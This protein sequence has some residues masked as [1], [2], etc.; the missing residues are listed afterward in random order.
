MSLNGIVEDRRRLKKHHV[1][2]LMMTAAPAIPPTTLPATA[3]IFKL[4]ELDAD[5]GYKSCGSGRKTG[6]RS[7]HAARMSD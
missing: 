3:P 1:A 5:V 2:R 6:R 4:V 7:K